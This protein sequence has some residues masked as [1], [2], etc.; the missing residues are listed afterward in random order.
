MKITMT[1]TKIV[2]V[3]NFHLKSQYHIT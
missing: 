2:P 3:N 1:Y